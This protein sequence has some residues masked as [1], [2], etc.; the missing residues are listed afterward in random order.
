MLLLLFYQYLEKEIHDS[1]KV[2]VSD[3][4]DSLQT[5]IYGESWTFSDAPNI[6]SF[7]HIYKHAL[8]V[9]YLFFGHTV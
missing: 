4:L 5:P 6:T 9:N 2:S 8:K 1:I 7:G 3:F